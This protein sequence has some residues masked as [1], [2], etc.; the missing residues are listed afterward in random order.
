MSLDVFGI[1]ESRYLSK[2]RKNWVN[3]FLFF[4]SPRFSFKFS[5]YLFLQELSAHPRAFRKSYEA[6][7]D[8]SARA[9]ERALPWRSRRKGRS[10]GREAVVLADF[11]GVCF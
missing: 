8:P 5:R 7:G 11:F 9:V 10:G 6:K 1:R 4:F 3:I 2:N